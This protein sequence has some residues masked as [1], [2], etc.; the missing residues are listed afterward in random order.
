M[1]N[2]KLTAKH[3]QDFKDYLF[4]E[5]KNAAT[6]E[7]YCCDVQK[8]LSFTGE[9]VLIKELVI[10][11]KKHME[12]QGYAVRSI[13]SMLS[14]LNG[15][16]EYLGQGSLKVKLV[17]IQRRVYCEERQELSKAEYLRLLDAAKGK[18]S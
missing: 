13:N 15:F 17:R 3:L 2:Y 16:L 8:F 4:Q 7:K 11:C 10:A 1:E 6:V 5:G 18:R 14:S 9:R 12:D